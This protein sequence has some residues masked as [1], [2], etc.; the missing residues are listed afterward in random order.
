MTISRSNLSIKVIGQ[1]QGHLLE[2]ENLPCPI[3]V[4]TKTDKANMLCGAFPERM[5]I[6]ENDTNNVDEV[7][8][9]LNDYK[10]GITCYI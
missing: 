3:Y 9:W 8:S 6:L 10:Q 5:Y 4:D 1:G 7:A 2:E